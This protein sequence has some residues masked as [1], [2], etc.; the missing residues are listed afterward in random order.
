LEA[1]CRRRLT[2]YNY[3]SFR[4]SRRRCRRAE[5]ACVDRF[6][7]KRSG[8]CRMRA[9]GA[10][11]SDLP[12][13]ALGKSG[14]KARMTRFDITLKSL[15]QSA[16]GTRFLKCLAIQGKY[17]E[18]SPVFPNTRERRAK[19][20]GPRSG[21]CADGRSPCSRKPEPSANAKS[22]AGCRTAPIRPLASAP[23]SSPV[24][25]RHRAS[26]RM[27]RLPSCTKCWTRLATPARNARLAN[28][29]PSPAKAAR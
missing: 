16:A 25:I 24:G 10:E 4:P 6:A 9:I 20:G 22:M 2:T 26:L 28:E 13:A 29:E 7:A 15:L 3:S 12:A 8:L 17:S 21:R 11:V 27:Q 14:R 18:L 19:N 5:R 1:A 23:S